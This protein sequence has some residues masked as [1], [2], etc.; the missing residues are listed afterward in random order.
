MSEILNEAE[1]QKN[2]LISKMNTIIMA[3]TDKNNLP[4]SSYAPS[5]VDKNNHFYIYVSL[6]SKHTKNLISNKNVSFMIIQDE[7]ESDNIFGRKRLTIDA[8]AELI[9]RNSEKWTKVI[10]KMEIKFGETLSY[11]RDMT[12]FNLFKLVP[13]KGLLVHG[14]ARA[15]TFSGEKLS[16]IN[17]LNEAGHS[18]K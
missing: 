4:N 11:L 8:C 2:N 16:E 3:T 14:F 6:L 17:Y 15:F 10:E 18:K 7:L 13:E 9:D 12:D 5:Y 1:K